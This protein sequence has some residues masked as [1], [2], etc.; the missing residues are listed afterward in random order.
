MNTLHKSWQDKR[1]GWTYR[2]RWYNRP[3]GGVR[4][5]FDDEHGVQDI[6]YHCADCAQRAYD[7]FKKEYA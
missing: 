1:P 3:D 2:V 6:D 5:R 4:L 7:Q